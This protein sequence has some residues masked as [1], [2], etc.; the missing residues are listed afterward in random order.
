MIFWDL[1]VWNR[2][3]SASV[4]GTNAPKF[5]F[6]DHG[7]VLFGGIGIILFHIWTICSFYL[8]WC[9]SYLASNEVKDMFYLGQNTFVSFNTRAFL[10][11]TPIFDI[12]KPYI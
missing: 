1:S 9:S 8:L 4:I 7:C 6:M 5:V 12:S 3:Y 10:K 11:V 2:I